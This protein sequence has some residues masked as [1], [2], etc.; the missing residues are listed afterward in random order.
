MYILFMKPESLNI[1]QPCG[2]DVGK[3]MDV[4]NLNSGC[5]KVVEHIYMRNQYSSE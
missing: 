1:V 3:E 5:M 4:V 2:K